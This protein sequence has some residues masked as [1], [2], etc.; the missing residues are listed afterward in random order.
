MQ[1]TIGRENRYITIINGH[2]RIEDKD[3]TTYAKFYD[4]LTVRQNSTVKLYYTILMQ[5]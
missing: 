1:N 3:E 4:E 2:A 5:E